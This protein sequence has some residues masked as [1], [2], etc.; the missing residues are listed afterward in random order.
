V[1]WGWDGIGVGV[2]VGDH[3]WMVDVFSSKRAFV[4]NNRLMDFHWLSVCPSL[5]VDIEKTWLALCILQHQPDL[6]IT[7]RISI[8]LNLGPAPKPSVAVQTSKVPFHIP[9]RIS[10]SV[11]PFPPSNHPTSKDDIFP[12]P[13]DQR[14]KTST[15]V[16]YTIINL[17]RIPNRS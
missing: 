14:S 3:I 4:I 7:L 6:P 13:T 1:D 15:T 2:G 11:T 17:D 5:A 16:L 8:T 12:F 9:L 10:L